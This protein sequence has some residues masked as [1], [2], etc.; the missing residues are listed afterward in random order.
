MHSRQEGKQAARQQL[1]ACSGHLC[2]RES[3]RGGGDSGKP[4]TPA[5]PHLSLS[6]SLRVFLSFLLLS[7]PG[8]CVGGGA[9]RGEGLGDGV[10]YAEVRPARDL[11]LSCSAE[12]IFILVGSAVPPTLG[13]FHRGSFIHK[14]RFALQG[15]RG[16][17]D[18]LFR[19]CLGCALGLPGGGNRPTKHCR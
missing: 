3:D 15:G 12:A 5:L 10:S 4:H 1:E 2:L 14:P 7:L 6:M 13:Y 8:L 18:N 17:H 19:L 11:R 16:G 9:W